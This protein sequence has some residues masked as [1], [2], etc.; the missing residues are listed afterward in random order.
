VAL[1]QAQKGPAKI[2]SRPLGA[3]SKKHSGEAELAAAD[4]ENG[5]NK[6][7]VFHSPVVKML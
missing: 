4:T 6:R 2:A 5:M 3:Q 1:R 7:S